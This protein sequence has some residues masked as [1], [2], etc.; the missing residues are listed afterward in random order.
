MTIQRKLLVDSPVGVDF[1][2]E[3]EELVKA[4]LESHLEGGLTK[5]ACT[6]LL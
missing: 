2:V 3:E 5:L 6:A 1:A 4:S